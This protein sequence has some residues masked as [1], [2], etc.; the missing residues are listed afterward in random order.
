[1]CSDFRNSS[2]A[3]SPQVL[4][5]LVVRHLL[6]GWGVVHDILEGLLAGAALQEVPDEE[7]ALVIAAG[8]LL[9]D[10]VKAVV[11]D[12]DRGRVSRLLVGGAEDADGIARGE[13]S[14]DPA[15]A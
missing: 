15:G 11:A 9:D 5:A 14:L 4:D 7:A 3:S 2:R 8:V 10:I 6:G 12:S 13:G 1:M